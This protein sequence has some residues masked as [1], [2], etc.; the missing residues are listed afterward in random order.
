MTLRQKELPSAS[1]RSPTPINPY[2]PLSAVQP[3]LFIIVSA[4]V[5]SQILVIS[6]YRYLSS[7][8]ASVLFLECFSK[9]Q[10]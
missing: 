5:L 3:I 8:P 1:Q 7:D 10:M 6:G 4:T 9:L 2:Q